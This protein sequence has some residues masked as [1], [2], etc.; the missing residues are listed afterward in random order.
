[1]GNKFVQIDSGT[2][3]SPVV[4]DE[5]TIRSREP[6]DIADLMSKMSETI[7]TVTSTILDLKGEVDNVLKTIADTTNTA[8][9]LLNDVGDDAKAILASGKRVSADLQVII[10]GL[11]EGR[12]TAG[13]LLTDDAMYQSAKKVAADAEATMA[14]VREACLQAKTALA[15]FQSEGGPVK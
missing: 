15:N 2:E 5:G 11:R 12:G 3:Q 8:Q 1:V 7:D 4:P 6:F 9:D 13:R 14:N 10:T